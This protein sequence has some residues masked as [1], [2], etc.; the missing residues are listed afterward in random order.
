MQNKIY[1][2]NT[3]VT[4][5]LSDNTYVL[6]SLKDKIELPYFE[7]ISPRYMLNE[8]RSNIKNLF[9]TNTIRFL[10]E[11][12]VSFTELQNE[13]VLSYIEQN[14]NSN[15][16]NLD[17]DICIITGTILAEKI[18]SNL[19]WHKFEHSIN[20]DNPD[21]TQTVVDYCIQKSLV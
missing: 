17:K 10:E 16:F 4:H 7:I 5:D 11:I 2:F 3:I 18:P 12:I 14:Y 13:I 6:S 1:V 9:T 15:I 19:Y 8:I 21:I 20:L